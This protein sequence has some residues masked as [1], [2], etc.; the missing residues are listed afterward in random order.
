MT[1]IVLCSTMSIKTIN[2]EKKQ[3]DNKEKERER[4]YIDIILLMSNQ[5]ANNLIKRIPILP[6]GNELAK[7]SECDHSNVIY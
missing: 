2:I 6:I 4:E 3:G 5:M 1:K 7:F